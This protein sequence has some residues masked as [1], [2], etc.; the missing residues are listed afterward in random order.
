MM[1]YYYVILNVIIVVNLFTSN[2]FTLRKPLCHASTLSKATT[3]RLLGVSSVS[4]QGSLSR[5]AAQRRSSA[6]DAK[7]IVHT[8]VSS[9]V[10]FCT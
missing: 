3:P 6:V 10:P 5:P 8:M 1:F 7:G 2:M 9:F 4:S